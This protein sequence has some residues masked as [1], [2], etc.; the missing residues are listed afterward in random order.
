MI[1]VFFCTAAPNPMRLGFAIACFERWKQEPDA[2]LHILRT[3]EDIHWWGPWDRDRSLPIHN[4]CCIADF[5]RERRIYADEVS[6]TDPYILADDDC[7]LP[8]YLELFQ[9]VNVFRYYNERILRDS[10]RFAVLSL[11][12]SN[13]PISEWTPEDYTPFSDDIVMEHVSVGGIRICRKGL[14]KNWPP[15]RTA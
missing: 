11:I 14:L 10:N 3:F 8:S 9:A 4:I 5:Q 13:A 7:L 6:Q 12:P 2:R 15:P 1:D